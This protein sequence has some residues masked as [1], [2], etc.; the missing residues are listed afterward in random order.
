MDGIDAKGIE[1]SVTVGTLVAFALDRPWDPDLMGLEM[2]WAGDDEDGPWVV[3]LD[4]LARDALAGIE[5]ARMPELA[6]WWAGIEELAEDPEWM[7]VV[8]TGLVHVAR[9]ARD[10]GQHVYCWMSL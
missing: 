3:E 10:A 7:L 5:D 9:R 4:D 1:P 8:L 2:V 6:R